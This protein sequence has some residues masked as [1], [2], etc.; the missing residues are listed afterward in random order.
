M[1]ARFACP[2]RAI[3]PVARSAVAGVRKGVISGCIARGLAGQDD[4]CVTVR[5]HGLAQAR[6]AARGMGAAACTACLPVM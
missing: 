3:G 6:K 5:G 4:T 1:A 2:G